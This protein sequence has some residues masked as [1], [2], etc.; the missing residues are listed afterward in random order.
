MPEVEPNGSTS[1][2]TLSTPLKWE[3]RRTGWAKVSV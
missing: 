2:I 3:I 1:G